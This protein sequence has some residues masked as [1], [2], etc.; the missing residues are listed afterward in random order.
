MVTRR[1]GCLPDA[2]EQLLRYPPVR[3]KARR[4]G[5]P[6]ARSPTIAANVERVG[7]AHQIMSIPDGL[8]IIQRGARASHYEIVPSRP[9]TVEQFQSLLNRIEVH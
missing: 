3:A 9:M 1:A 7:G 8:E 2:C 6:A 4:L 5:D